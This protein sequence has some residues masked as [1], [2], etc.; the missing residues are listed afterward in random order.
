[1]GI[2]MQ[3]RMTLVQM[4]CIEGKRDENYKWARGLLKD[5]HGEGDLEYILFPELFDIGFRK[6]DYSSEGVG[7]PGP[8]SEFLMSIAEEF[9]SYVI[10][11]GIEAS[12]GKYFNTLV[13]TTPEGKILGTYR[14]I[15]PF[16][17]EREFFEGG[18][19]LAMLEIRGMKVGVQI[20]YDLRFPE[21]SRRLALEGAEL[22]LIPAAFPDPRSAHWDTLVM[23]RAIENQL[24]VAATNRVGFAFDGKTYFGHSQLIDPWGVRLTRINSAE[25]VFTSLAD[26]EMIRTARSQ[27][28]CYADR[29]EQGYGNVQWFRDYGNTTIK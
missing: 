3:F 1:M 13:V 9:S 18:T 23:A 24:Y 6:E 22:L 26:T 21:V 7:V 20:C 2:S 15:H 10:G 8:T 12:N 19:V 25:Q 4:P 29:P 5:H 28:T 16:Q 17:E 11:T 14:K 27:I